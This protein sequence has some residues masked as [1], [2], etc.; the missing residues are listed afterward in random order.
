MLKMSTE[1]GSAVPVGSC[2][3][4][5][6]NNI[7]NIRQIVALVICRNSSTTLPGFVQKSMKHDF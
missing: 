6:V 5:T 2:V 3:L 1:H 7:E 4:E